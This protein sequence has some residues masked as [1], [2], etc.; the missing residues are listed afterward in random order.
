MELL[1][2]DILY[3]NKQEM[4]AKFLQNLTIGIYGP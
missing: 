4:H 3:W 2:M 1:M